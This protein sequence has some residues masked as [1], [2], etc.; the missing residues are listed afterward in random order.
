M[1]PSEIK[2]QTVLGYL[3]LDGEPDDV[4][5]DT[6]LAAAKSYI[7]SYTGLD[8]AEMDLHEEI[9]IAILVLCSDLYDN[10]QTAVESDK[11]NRT[12]RSIL[13]LHSTNLL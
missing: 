5:P 2:A 3:R 7:M 11:V 12:V 1:K 10:R 6:L 13:D 4:S 8:E 9:S